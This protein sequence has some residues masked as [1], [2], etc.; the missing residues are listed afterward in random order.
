MG[1]DVGNTNS[2]SSMHTSCSSNNNSSSN[3]GNTPPKSSSP[4][5][6]GSHKKKPRRHFGSSGE[7]SPPNPNPSPSPSPSPSPPAN[8]KP[9]PLGDKGRDTYG[10]LPGRGYNRYFTCVEGGNEGTF[11]QVT[12]LGGRDEELRPEEWCVASHGSEVGQGK[13]AKKGKRERGGGHLPHTG[14]LLF[15]T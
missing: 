7:G 15:L 12:V 8:P 11:S 14:D 5:Q 13:K 9:T 3:G 10:N 2:S 6:N 1:K 4:P